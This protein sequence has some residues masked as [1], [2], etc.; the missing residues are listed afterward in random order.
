MDISSTIPKQILPLL[1]YVRSFVLLLLLLLSRKEK[2]RR[3]IAGVL[4]CFSPWFAQPDRGFHYLLDSGAISGWRSCQRLDFL[5]PFSWT[6][7]KWRGMCCK[8]GPQLLQG[9]RRLCCGSA[10]LGQAFGA[11]A[12]WAF[13]GIFCLCDVFPMPGNG[14]KC[15]RA[16]WSDMHGCG[17]AL[18]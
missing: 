2:A 4:F 12:E 1:G 5:A 17:L 13:G 10:F 15:P 9:P 6:T 3:R 11:S 18:K 14:V 7:P 8:M 16:G